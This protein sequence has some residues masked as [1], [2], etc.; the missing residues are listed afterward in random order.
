MMQPNK[1]GRL[2][3]AVGLAVFFSSGCSAKENAVAGDAIYRNQCASCHG[4]DLEGIGVFPGLDSGSRTAS[5]SD[6][7]ITK[8]IEDGP[9]GMPAFKGRLNAAQ[10]E[11]LIAYLRQV[12][13]ES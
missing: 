11:A 9:L 6:A 13:A 5:M 3:L 10:T 2:W 4:A 12:Q 7:E 1:L 8:I